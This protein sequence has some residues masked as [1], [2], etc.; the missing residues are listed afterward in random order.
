MT[1]LCSSR[2]FTREKVRK[3]YKYTNRRMAVVKMVR[4]NQKVWKRKVM[5][6]VWKRYTSF[7]FA[8]N[9][10]CTHNPFAGVIAFKSSG[11]VACFAIHRLICHLNLWEQS[12]KQGVSNGHLNNRFFAT[13]SNGGKLIIDHSHLVTEK[14]ACREKTLRSSSSAAAA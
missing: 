3:C 10:I 9:Y 6:R 11:G 7:P 14:Q 13:V 1:P 4:G 2:N 12:D 8:V 5:K